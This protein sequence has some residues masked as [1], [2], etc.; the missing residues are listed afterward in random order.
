MSQPPP[1][2]K[3]ALVAAASAFEER[4]I[5]FAMPWEGDLDDL[6]R[7]RYQALVEACRAYAKE[8]NHWR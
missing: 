5:Q 3:H 4:G 6:E 7:E 1:R 2:E 8:M